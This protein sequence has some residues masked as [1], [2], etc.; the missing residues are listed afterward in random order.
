M[1]PPRHRAIRRRRPRPTA[2]LPQRVL[3]TADTVGGVWTYAIE[4]AQGLARYEID[5]V[6]ATMGAP[7]SAAQRREVA[8]LSNVELEESCFRLEWMPDPWHDVDEAGEWLLAV[9]ARTHPDVIHLNG[10]AH[11]ALPWN[12]PVL[13]VG[14]SCVLSW[15]AA[16]RGGPAPAE[17]GEYR[18]RVGAG[19]HAADAVVTPSAAMLRALEEHYGPIARAAVIHNARSGRR[20]APAASK[21]PFILSA[22]RLWDEAKNV[23]LLDA[24]APQ[25]AWPVAVAAHPRP[26]S[27]HDVTLPHLQPLGMLEPEVLA[28]WYARASIY[29]LPARY[30]PFG[31]SVLEAALAGCALVLGDIPSLREMWGDTA[32]WAPPDDAAAWRTA[33]NEL[34]ADPPRRADLARRARAHACR[35]NPARFAQAYVATYGRLLAIDREIEGAL[36]CAS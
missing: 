24:I 31:L 4:L 1:M 26:E 15:H 20:Y 3:M 33:L 17:W 27:G 2:V 34:I 19:L 21:E 22:G 32:V 9:A 5:V 13:T 35:Y 7:L 29:A 36:S 6:L 16:V 28:Q 18:C 8:A 12:A 25:L 30:E 14:H 10:Y 11:A 23:G